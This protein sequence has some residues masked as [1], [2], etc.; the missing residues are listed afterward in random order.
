MSSRKRKESHKVCRYAVIGCPIKGCPFAHN[1]AEFL[2]RRC[3]EKD[4]T[5][6]YLHTERRETKKKLFERL[7]AELV[8]T[9]EECPYGRNCPGMYCPYDREKFPLDWSEDT[10]PPDYAQPLV[11]KK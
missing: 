1:E 9:A 11:W 2:P 5:C 10:T 7:T 6:G 4:C 3:A 8:Q